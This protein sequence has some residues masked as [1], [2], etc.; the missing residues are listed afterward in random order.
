MCYINVKIL[1]ISNNDI[2]M[3]TLSFLHIS[4]WK[5]VLL[6][7]KKSD[8]DSLNANQGN[9]NILKSIKYNSF[10]FTE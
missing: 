6:F 1:A 2:T 5:V 8:L 7:P 10:K 4:E 3:P 9:E